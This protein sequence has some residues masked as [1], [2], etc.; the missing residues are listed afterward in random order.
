[1]RSGDLCSKCTW[2]KMASDTVTTK[3]SKVTLTNWERLNNA[4][5]PLGGASAVQWNDHMFVLAQDGTTLLYR[6][7]HKIWSMLPKSPYNNSG[8]AVPT[9]LTIHN[10]Q[11]LTMNEKANVIT[12]DPLIAEWTVKKEMNVNINGKTIKHGILD[13]YN[14]TLYAVVLYA[15]SWGGSDCTAFSYDSKLGK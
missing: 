15:S 7:E 1:M 14:N 12:F 3:Q 4:P 2:S 10:G 5:L 13:S 9:T 6:P 11:I 8:T